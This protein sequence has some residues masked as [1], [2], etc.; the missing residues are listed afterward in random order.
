[1]VAAYS[2][3]C[4]QAQDAATDMAGQ[5]KAAVAAA[6][7]VLQE[8]ATAVAKQLQK[9]IPEAHGM[10][11]PEDAAPAA[12]AQAQDVDAAPQASDDV[13]GSDSEAEVK[14]L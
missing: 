13:S 8:S 11:S 10:F 2:G 6:E 3:A 12:D 9:P 7:A 14:S 4:V 1:M 5:T